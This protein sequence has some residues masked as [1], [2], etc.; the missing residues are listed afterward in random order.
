[1]QVKQD[2]EHQQKMNDAQTQKLG[3]KHQQ[4]TQV[5]AQKHTVQQQ[6]LQARQPQPR[7][8]EPRARK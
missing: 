4:Q 3:Q 1:L 8:S 6:S 5:L 7:L 2:T